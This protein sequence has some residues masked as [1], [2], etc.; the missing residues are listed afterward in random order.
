[1]WFGDMETNMQEEILDIVDWPAV[2]VVFA[3][4]HGR[5]SG[6]MPQALLDKLQPSVIIIGEAPS[7]H[8]QYYADRN[9]ITQNTAG[10]IVL[11]CV[12]GSTHFHVANGRY[13]RPFLEVNRGVP[14]VVGLSYIGTLSTKPR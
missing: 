8:L 9:T 11:D 14:R 1:M 2:D 10:D 12:A 13:R 7:E 6:T 5:D 3:P 4:H